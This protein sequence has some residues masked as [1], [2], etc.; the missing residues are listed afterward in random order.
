MIRAAFAA[1][2]LSIA[3]VSGAYAADDAP[4]QKPAEKLSL[5]EEREAKLDRL[6]AKLRKAASPD[7]AEVSVNAIWQQWL[8]NDSPTAQV[9][10]VQATRAMEAKDYKAAHAILDPLVEVHPG[11]MEAWN[12]RATL[13]YLE[14]RYGE[15]VKD[16]AKVLDLEPR[17]FGALAGLGMIRRLQGDKVGAIRA[18]RDALAVNPS[19]PGIKEAIDEM[20]GEETPI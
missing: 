18:F 20:G 13:F 15:S 5:A 11:Y 6:F 16:I 17:H 19:M 8:A 2:F 4:A 14:G 3:S 10:L 12:K 7:E 9:L 1:L